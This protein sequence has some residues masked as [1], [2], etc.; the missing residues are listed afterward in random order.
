[1]LHGFAYPQMD[2]SRL[3]FF[4]EV[5]QSLNDDIHVIHT[6]AKQQE[7]DDRVHISKKDAHVEAESERGTQWEGNYHDAHQGE[8]NLGN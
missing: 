1:M 8:K 5:L 3:V 4:A 7:G 2:R 6:N